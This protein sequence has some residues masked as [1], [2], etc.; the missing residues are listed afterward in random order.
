MVEAIAINYIALGLYA[1]TSLIFKSVWIVCMFASLTA[2]FHVQL[3]AVLNKKTDLYFMKVKT[4]ISE[5]WVNFMVMHCF[6]ERKFL[7]MNYIITPI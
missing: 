2:S 1:R 7:H 4:G 3:E 6:Q 5:E